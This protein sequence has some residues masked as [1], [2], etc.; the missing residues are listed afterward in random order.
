V[1]SAPEPHV[2]TERH[3]DLFLQFAR[4]VVYPILR[5]R[6]HALA[7]TDTLTGLSNNR[8][9][10]R[11][12][13]EEIERS[14]RYQH[15][16]SLI[17]VDL[18]HFKRVNDTQ[19]HPAGDAILA[20]VGWVL[21]RC[22]RATDLAARYGG[23]EMAVLCPETRPV[24][25]LILAERIREA[26]EERIFELPTGGKL[27]ITISLGIASVPDHGRDA[28][29]LIDAAD[30]ALYDAK[31]MGRNRVCVASPP[32]AISTIPAVSR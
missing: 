6:L 29:E 17:F 3:R 16:L 31:S 32:G 14:Q 22:S 4:H 18:D 1:V 10:R 20:Q 8:A 7:T 21:R 2:F 12:L 28:Q 26:I 11:R 27:K 23:E 9:F 13:Q 15:P 19:G 5:M 24:D 30:R 25:A